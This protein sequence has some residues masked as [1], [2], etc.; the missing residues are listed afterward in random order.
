[1]ELYIMRHGDAIDRAHPSVTS[2]EVRDLTDSGRDETDLMAR[3]LVRLNVRPDLILTSPLV[4]ARQTAEIVAAVT[5]STAG[6]S[7]CDELVPGG[8]L[9]GVLNDILSHGR[10]ARTLLTGHM[11]GVGA[12][13]GYYVWGSSDIVV[14][15]RTAEICRVDLPDT[16]PAPGYGDLRWAIPPRIA[17]RLV[18]S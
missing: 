9:A 14:P 10:P 5:G 2:D 13:V 6:V 3:L 8:S 15:F 18:G 1:V 7:V 12:M 4:R 11:P 16:T 17:R